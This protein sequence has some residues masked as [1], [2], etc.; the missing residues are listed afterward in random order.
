M[1]IISSNILAGA[2]GSGV[3]AYEIEQ[4]LRF[5]NAY[6]SRTPSSAGNRRTF[7]FSV[8]LKKTESGAISGFFGAWSTVEGRDVF[9]FDSNSK[10]RIFFGE[11]V[12]ANIISNAIYRDSSAWYHVVVAVDTTQATAA[13]RIKLWI[14]GESVSFGTAS[15]P[16]QNT[17]LHVNN[18]VAHYI[19]NTNA[20]TDQEWQGYLAEFHLVDGTA[21]DHEDFGEF[22]NNGVWRPIEYT[23]SHGTNGFYLTF[24][25]SATNGIGHDHSGNGNNFS[26]TGF[27]TTPPGNGLYIKNMSTVSGGGSF[28]G[29]FDGNLSTQ[30]ASQNF[31]G[32]V[33]TWTPSGGYAY[34][35]SVEVYGG[36]AA[37]DQ[38]RINGGSYTAMPGSSWKTIASGSGTITTIDFRDSRG[39]AAA[40]FSAIRVDGVILVDYVFNSRYDVMS[41]TPTTNWC[42]L[43]PLSPSQ[44][45]AVLANGNLDCT[46]TGVSGHTRRST[47]AVGSGK[48]YAEITRGTSTLSVG[49]V[50]ADL[51]LLSWPGNST[52]G[53]TGSYAYR[54]DNGNKY[55]NGNGSSYG[56]TVATGDVIGI[57]YDGDNG[58]L[59]FSKNGTWQ[60]SGDPTSGASATG[61][62]FTGLGN[63]TWTIACGNAG[64]STNG[65]ATNFN[66]GQRAFAYTPPTG[67]KALNT[68]NLPAPDIK[69]GSQYFDAKLY[70][71]NT[72]TN[73]I[74][75]FNFSPDFVWIK[76]RSHASDNAVYDIVR[77]ANKELRTNQTAAEFTFTDSLNSFDSDGFTLG[78]D[79]GNGNVNLSGRTY[80]TWAWDAGG[81]GSSNTDGTITST[82]SANPT[83]GFS[84]VTYTGNGTSG[85][86]WGHGLGV[87]PKMVIFKNRDDGGVNANWTVYNESIG[88]A[89]NLYLNT[90]NS[91]TAAS[92]F[93][94]T[95]PSS[96]VFTVKNHIN[97]NSLN[98]KYVAYCFAEVEGYSKFGSY[99]GNGSTDGP[100]VALNFRPAWVL[101]R[102]T[103]AISDWYLLDS[104]RASYNPAEPQL[105]AN[106]AAAETPYTGW[107]DLL[108]NGFKV[109]R[110]DAAWNGSGSTYIFAAFAEHPT[111]GDGVSPATAR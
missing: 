77:G 73:A 57:A 65:T 44:S 24:D 60:N 82:V 81:T 46:W 72:S 6:L 15:Y 59:Y 62:A 92:I 91:V 37:Y 42:T 105:I 55:N 90:T 9:R 71:G 89:N 12:T 64:G 74:T 43:N 58:A 83:A 78:T 5:N 94:D 67:Y 8:W 13:N 10:F 34:T 68:A 79:T 101:I 36:E 53:S 100:F 4:S 30:A 80:V 33:M 20:Q 45:E 27:T 84:I 61:A 102:Q 85:A 111:G 70:S 7:T 109:R 98:Y 22:D 17:N 97:V 95:A 54:T 86:T 16:S 51:K 56:S 69:D 39:N 3:S 88:L 31:S 21:L 63:Q 87:T 66:F 108:S 76:S 96:T 104:T 32:E 29:G 28:G 1:S 107:G 93:W 40:A 35:S 50:D 38:V 25:P 99:T 103:N 75:G 47:I 110:T 52:Y 11:T 18:T 19:G 41:D 2:A 23:G 106:T 26:P 14:N 49:L 48:W